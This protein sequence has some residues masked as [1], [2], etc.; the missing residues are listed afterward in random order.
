MDG[1]PGLASAFR[2]AF[3]SARTARCWVHKARNVFTKVPRRY[4]ARFQ[5]DWDRVQYAADLASAKVAFASLQERSE[6]DCGDAVGLE[7]GWM[8]TS[9]TA[10]SLPHLAYQKKKHVRIEELTQGLLN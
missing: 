3:P 5:Q 1:L 10:S 8:H 4:Q 6:K 7:F 9:I 2:E